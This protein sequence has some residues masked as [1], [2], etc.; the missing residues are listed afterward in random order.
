MLLGFRIG[1]AALNGEKGQKEH[2]S[3][4]FVMQILQT[5]QSDYINAT[6]TRERAFSRG[7][8]RQ[9]ARMGVNVQLE[10]WRNQRLIG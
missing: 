5:T 1:C 7:L 4:R 10:S 6:S 3:G 8:A 9:C 2:W